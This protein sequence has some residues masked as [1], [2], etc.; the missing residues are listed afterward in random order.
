MSNFHNFALNSLAKK[1][2]NKPILETRN[3]NNVI[4]VDYMYSFLYMYVKNMYICI[5]FVFCMYIYIYIYNMYIYIYI[6]IYIYNMHC[7]KE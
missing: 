4:Y 3:D 1:R 7:K 5:Y 6:Y 2:L